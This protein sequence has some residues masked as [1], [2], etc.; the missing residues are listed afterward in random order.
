[1]RHALAPE[2]AKQLNCI[3]APKTNFDDVFKGGNSSCVTY[4]HEKPVL[5]F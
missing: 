3:F 4:E 5:L 2:L 1:M